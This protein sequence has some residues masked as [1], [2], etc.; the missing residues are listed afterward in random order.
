VQSRSSTAWGWCRNHHILT[1]TKRER[2]GNVHT[3]GKGGA[4]SDGLLAHE[5]VASLYEGEKGGH[6]N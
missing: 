6:L 5:V 2:K 1:F 4:K 3:T